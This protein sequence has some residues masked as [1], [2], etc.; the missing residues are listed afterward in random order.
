MSVDCLKS[1]LSGLF[2]HSFP[3]AQLTAIFGFGRRPVAFTEKEL[4]DFLSTL[5]KKKDSK[6][7]LAS[8][9]RRKTY[10]HR[11]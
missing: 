4:R 8:P 1:V 9:W 6:S 3:L 7:Q 11:N 5:Q 2:S 10:C